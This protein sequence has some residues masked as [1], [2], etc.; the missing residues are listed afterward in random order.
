MTVLQP[1]NDPT[2]LLAE[3]EELLR[4]QKRRL[5]HPSCSVRADAAS[6]L[7]PMG[8][9]VVPVLS[10]AL[11]DRH[12]DVRL[13]AI[14]SL[15][16]IGNTSAIDAL[17]TA[18]DDEDMEVR[19]LAA[20]T[21]ASL[22]GV[23]T[24]GP[25]CEALQHRDRNTRMVAAQALG[26]LGDARAVPHLLE[27][28]R[29]CFIGRSARGQL[30]LGL[31]VAAAVALTFIGFLWG[32]FAAKMG[33]MMGCIHI[34][35]R[36]GTLYFQKRKEQSEVAAAISNALLQIAENTLAPEVH[37][38]VPELRTVMQD[39]L[40][41]SKEARAAAREAADRIE[42][43]TGQLQDLPLAAAPAEVPAQNTLPRPAEGIVTPTVAHK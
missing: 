14:S 28:H 9:C 6:R 1:Q 30:L 42:K 35:I 10:E 39:R 33:G 19:S 23:S 24:M 15:R 13:A 22:G 27:A 29:R 11:T 8:I 32:T 31:T 7:A 17:A 12:V 4:V 34:F 40:Q 37:R 41:H 26:T 38:I 21:I 43:L 3:Q 5:A 16:Q 2:H 36:V 25:L 18:L 20:T